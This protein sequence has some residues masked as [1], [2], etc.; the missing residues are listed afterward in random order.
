MGFIKDVIDNVIDTVVDVVDEVVDTVVDVVE[1]VVSWVIPEMPELPEFNATPIDS[2]DLGTQGILLNKRKSDS[3]LPL[4]YGTRRVGGNIVWL[5][6][7]DDNQYLYVVLALCE[8]QVA[9]FTELYLDDQFYATYTGS[10][11][12]FGTAT[13]ISS[14]SNLTTPTPTTAPIR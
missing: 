12:T 10:D 9:R 6:T 1:E 4:L 8:G 13:T 7:T 11:S 14:K 3:S 2:Q 5:A